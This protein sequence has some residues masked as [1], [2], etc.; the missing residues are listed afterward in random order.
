MPS[1]LSGPTDVLLPNWSRG[2]PIALDV[3]VISSMQQLT[4]AEAASSPGHVLRVGVQRKLTVHLS[5]CRSAGVDSIPLV[6]ESLRRWCSDAIST[7][8]SIGHAIG[9]RDNST[10][11]LLKYD[12]TPVRLPSDRLVAGQCQLLDSSPTNP[13]PSLDN[14]I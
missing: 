8:R 6:V 13:P 2:C 11:S 10:E 4:L 7:I 1:S 3:H 14:L 5:A 9:Q 12:Q